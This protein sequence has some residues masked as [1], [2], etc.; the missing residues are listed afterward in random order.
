MYLE[1]QNLSKG[2]SDKNFIS[3]LA[4]DL[5]HCSWEQLLQEVKLVFM[6]LRKYMYRDTV[7]GSQGMPFAVHKWHAPVIPRKR[8]V[9]VILLS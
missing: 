7:S 6:S 1:C 2:N 8:R 5:L 9:Q 4:A 3:T